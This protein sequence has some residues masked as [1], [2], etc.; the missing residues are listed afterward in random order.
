MPTLGKSTSVV[1]LIALVLMATVLSSR[2]IDHGSFFFINDIIS[3]LKIHFYI[4]YILR[5]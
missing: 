1:C 2:A 4:V 3:N 5:S